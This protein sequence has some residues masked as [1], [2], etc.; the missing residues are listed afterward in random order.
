LNKVG[1]FRLAG[2]TDP[3]IFAVMAPKRPVVEHII[4]PAGTGGD[5]GMVWKWT[6]VIDGED[7]DDGT[8]TGAESKARDACRRAEMLWWERK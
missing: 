5:P 6:L 2:W 1:G 8:V 4:T 7:I 3:A